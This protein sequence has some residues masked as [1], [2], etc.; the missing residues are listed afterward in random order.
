[1]LNFVV[2]GAL[3]GV[4]TTTF[5]APRLLAANNSSAFGKA[6]CDCDDLTTLT[7]SRFIDAQM[8]GC[9]VGVGVGL[10]AA[11]VFR[12]WRRKSRGAIRNS[13]AT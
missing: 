2:G 7:I 8:A 12:R 11:L 3:A 4:L 5:A 9:A 13:V 6:L 10:L 1:M